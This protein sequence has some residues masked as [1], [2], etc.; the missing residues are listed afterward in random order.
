MIDEI[1]EGQ[2]MKLLQCTDCHSINEGAATERTARKI[3]LVDKR[4]GFPRLRLSVKKIN[5]LNVVHEI[6]DLAENIKQD[7]YIDYK[8]NHFSDFQRRPHT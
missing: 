6:R 5:E 7:K 4:I 3:W 2:M 1:E 8:T